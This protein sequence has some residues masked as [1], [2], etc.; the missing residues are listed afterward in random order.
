MF[1][2]NLAVSV[3]LAILLAGFAPILASIYCDRRA[4]DFTLARAGTIPLSGLHDPAF[5][6][7]SP[8][9]MLNRPVSNMLA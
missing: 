3:V 4:F 5:R 1:W 2:I 7:V 8:P 6:V 9:T